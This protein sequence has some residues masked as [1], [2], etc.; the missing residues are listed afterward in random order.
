MLRRP[1]SPPVNRELVKLNGEPF[2]VSDQKARREL[3]YVP[4]ITRDAG[5]ERLL[6]G[7]K[8]AVTSP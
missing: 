7:R 6:A 2:V 8:A 1:G 4:V 5:L 3:G